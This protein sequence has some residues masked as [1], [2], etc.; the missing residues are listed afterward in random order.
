[1]KYKNLIELAAAYR[2]GEI[3]S[4]E[5]VLVLDNDSSYL[6]WNGANPF[7]RNTRAAEDF[8]S[9]K[10]D[11]GEKLFRGKGYSDLED[12]CKAAGIPAE[13]C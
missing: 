10:Y 2:S 12:A 7:G 5:W 13:W 3:K 8:E 4:E 6:R 1:M 11:E 9:A